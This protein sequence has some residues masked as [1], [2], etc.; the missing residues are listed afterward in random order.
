[1]QVLV[2]TPN[3][4]SEPFLC[5][6]IIP[7]A[8]SQP[9]V[10]I[11]FNASFIQ[12]PLPEPEPVNSNNRLVSPPLF[13][14]LGSSHTALLAFFIFSAVLFWRPQLPDGFHCV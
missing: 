7:W 14:E 6:G 9:R 4:T 13:V 11:S 5:D 1:M 8:L 2:E 12:V 3:Q 10:S